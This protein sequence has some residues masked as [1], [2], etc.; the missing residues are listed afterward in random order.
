MLI[1]SRR[2]RFVRPRDRAF[3]ILAV[4]HADA[5]REPQAAQLLRLRLPHA[6]GGAQADALEVTSAGTRANDGAPMDHHAAEEAELLGVAG[7]GLHVA[8]RLQRSQLQRADLVLGMAREHSEVAIDLRPEIAPRTFTL[9]G[10]TMLV[11]ALASGEAGVPVEPLGSAGPAPFMRSV[12]RAADAARDK[13]APPLPEVLL[14]ILDPYRHGGVYRRS[15]ESIDRNVARLA[16]AL[17]ELA[18]GR[19]ADGLDASADSR[20]LVQLVA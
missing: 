2:P 15:V 16:I 4:G 14:D 12:V 3:R 20:R 11:E 9:V 5:C 18:S 7:T 6:F 17:D 1:P 13:V 10:F 8:R 19:A